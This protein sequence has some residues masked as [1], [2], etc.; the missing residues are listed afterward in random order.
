MSTSFLLLLF[1]FSLRGEGERES[2]AIPLLQLAVCHRRYFD[3]ENITLERGE[4]AY[5]PFVEKKEAATLTA[6][7]EKGGRGGDER[8]D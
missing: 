2:E 8:R 6:V 7:P 4:I 3:C 1:V 5:I